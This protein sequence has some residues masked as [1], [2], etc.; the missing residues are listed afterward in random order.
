M[1]NLLLV[2]SNWLDG[3]VIAAHLTEHGFRVAVAING[4]E[5]R[6]TLS[7]SHFDLVL[8]DYDLAYENTFEPTRSLLQRSG[9]PF[10]FFSTEP[11]V[12]DRIIG[13]E[14]GAADFLTNPINPRELI[15]RIRNILTRVNSSS[16]LSSLEERTYLFSGWRLESVRRR[17]LS[18]SHEEV[19]LSGLE[20]ELLLFFLERPNRVLSRHAISAA[21]FDCDAARTGRA[22]DVAVARLRRKLDDTGTNN[23]LIQTVRSTGYVLSAYVALI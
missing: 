10:V 13:L 4:Y 23:S 12:L 6:R 18:S 20:Y 2:N 5:A 7:K 14:L 9:L 17:L 8:L 3:E 21:F 1:Y 22:I 15:A 19:T 16:S 11:S